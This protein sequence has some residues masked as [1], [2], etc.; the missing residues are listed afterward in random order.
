M[1]GSKKDYGL[2][3]EVKKELEANWEKIREEYNSI[4]ESDKRNYVD[5]TGYLSDEGKWKVFGLRGF[6]LGEKINGDKCMY[7]HSILDKIPRLRTAAFSI[8]KPKM[9][10]HPHRGLKDNTIR[11]HLGLITPKGPYI[12]I[13]GKTHYWEEGKILKFDDS[14][15]HEVDNPTNKERVILLFDVEEKFSFLLSIFKIIRK[16]TPKN[17]RKLFPLTE[18]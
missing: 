17:F 4:I 15:I 5:G 6:P 18:K 9:N 12:K 11:Y 10:I 16:V 14:V 2:P 7:T 8:L 1:I 13:K 3:Q